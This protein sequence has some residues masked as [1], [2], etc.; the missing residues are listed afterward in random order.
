VLKPLLFWAGAAVEPFA[1]DRRAW[2]A[3]ARPAVTVSDNDATAE[4]WAWAGG[5]ELLATIAARTGVAWH[6]DDGR[7]HPS[8]RVLITAGELAQAYAAFAQDSGDIAVQLRAWMR[9]V[10][11]AQSFGLRQVARDA[12]GVA[13]AAVALKCGWF[14]VER[15]HAVTLVE[16]PGRTLG[17]AVTTFR[18]PDEASAAAYAAAAGDNAE[19][20]ATHDA[21]AGPSVR[22]GTSRALEIAAA[23]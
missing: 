1:S 19:I 13:D 8:L 11:A 14:G 10:P 2:A 6:T 3:L 15:A 17:A 9:A 18:P 16:L 20:V 12:V 4:L 5:E 23:L 21:F 7:E 22:A